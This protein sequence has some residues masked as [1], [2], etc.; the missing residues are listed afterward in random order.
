[1]SDTL[2][3]CS[4]IKLRVS[5]GIE[6]THMIRKGQFVIDGADAMSFADPLSALAGMPRPV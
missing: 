1:M 3:G 6:R 2:L 4:G 5:G